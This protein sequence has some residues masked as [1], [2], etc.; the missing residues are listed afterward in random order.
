MTGTAPEA[1]YADSPQTSFPWSGPRA[2]SSFEVNQCTV[3]EARSSSSRQQSTRYCFWTTDAPA[4]TENVLQSPYFYV[5]P[6]IRSYAIFPQTNRYLWLVGEQVDAPPTSEGE[7]HPAH[8]GIEGT[9]WAEPNAFIR[10]IE[11]L[12]YIG[13]ISTGSTP[14]IS[15]ET[16]REAVL[17]WHLIWDASDRKMPIPVA[18]TGPDGRLL[19]TW[20]HGEHHLEL[21]F[22]PKMPAEFFYKNRRTRELWG[23]DYL[24]GDPIPP[25]AGKKLKSFI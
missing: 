9:S 18:C 3:D 8:V 11:H 12:K 20:D 17:A 4:P 16:A 7:V 23:E 19:Y 5:W 21:E 6:N 25:E 10:H 14:L 15:P 1:E 24:V 13:E 2:S 22:I